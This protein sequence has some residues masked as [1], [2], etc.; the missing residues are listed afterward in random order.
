MLE[1]PSSME[2]CSIGTGEQQFHGQRIAETVRVSVLHFGE[3]HHF[4]EYAAIAFAAALALLG[5]RI[6]RNGFPRHKSKAAS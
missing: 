3:L 6:F 5:I 4:A 1:W 2:T